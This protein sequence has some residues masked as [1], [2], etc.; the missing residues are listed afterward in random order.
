MGTY[1]RFVDYTRESISLAAAQRA[2]RPPLHTHTRFM[3]KYISKLGDIFERDFT[4]GRARFAQ[5]RHLLAV[6]R[7]HTCG[8]GR[9]RGVV[10]TVAS[11][12]RIPN[13]ITANHILYTIQYT[14]AHTFRAKLAPL[15]RR[16][17]AYVGQ[18]LLPMPVAGTP[19]RVNWT[20]NSR[21][22]R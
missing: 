5:L 2:L 16:C 22:L 7:T 1:T 6:L 15:D 12:A 11:S 3:R 13:P 18:I 9:R 10:F 8:L 4:L 19:A 20:H 14:T 21:A 17:C